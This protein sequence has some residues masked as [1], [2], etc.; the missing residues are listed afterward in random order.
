MSDYLTP[1]EL[2]RELRERSPASE[3]LI[4]S[5]HNCDR[6]HF[7][8]VSAKFAAMAAAAGV[9]QPHGFQLVEMAYA[10]TEP[11]KAPDVAFRFAY[12]SDSHLYARGMTHRFAKAVAKAVADVN[13]LDPQPDFVFY[14]GDLAQLGRAEELELGRQLLKDLKAPVKMMVGEH[15]WYL[16]MGDKWKEFFGPDHYVFDHKGVH[17]ITLN[18]VIEKDFW[19]AKGYTPE[20]RMNIVAGLDDGR[21]SRFEV[22]EEQRAWLK[23]DLAKV[24]K[25]TPI[26]VF[27]HSP[28][29]KYYEPWNFWTADAEQVQALL[30][31]FQ[32]VT[33]IHGH[34]H[35]LLTN[36]IK[37]IS[38][39]GLLSTA[40][41]WPYAPTGLPKLTLQMD[42]PNPFD[43][44]DGLGDGTIDVLKS[45]QANANYNLWD[46]ATKT[47]TYAELVAGIKGGGPSY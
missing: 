3:R 26:V 46:R 27:S 10:A 24:D 39:H 8:K 40:W 38:F 11:E 4:R 12:I 43:Q 22:G 36:R 47:V 34:T 20:Q 21:Q 35:Q 44:F 45:G 6:R 18:S 7:L 16:D 42:R 23:A 29:Y 41:P 31:P 19:T 5:L 14:G 9:I 33:V 30:F 15:D 1:K 17:F 13:A 2:E 32:T 37:N 28:L 25:K